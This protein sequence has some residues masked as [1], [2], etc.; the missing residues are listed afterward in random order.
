MIIKVGDQKINVDPTNWV[1][2]MQSV[3]DAI[4]NDLADRIK[5]SLIIGQYPVM[6]CTADMA[7][8]LVTELSS[9]NPSMVW[10]KAQAVAVGYKINSLG[11]AYDII[12]NLCLPPA[13]EALQGAMAQFEG[14]TC[15]WPPSPY[16]GQWVSWCKE[17]SASIQ[18]VA[19]SPYVDKL[20]GYEAWQAGEICTS[21]VR[22]NSPV[23][24]VYN[25]EQGGMVRTW[26]DGKKSLG[27][28]S[29]H[30]QAE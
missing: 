20:N 13:L 24:E 28:D 30:G 26:F 15:Q 17:N 16:A 4:D 11:E 23:S 8:K 7:R 5:K 19:G 3:K 10:N 18:K 2:T 9:F 22:F 1:S 12:I 21:W 29:T 14:V 25:S 27:Y 6:I